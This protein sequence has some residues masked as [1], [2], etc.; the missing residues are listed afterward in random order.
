MKNTL[1]KELFLIL[2]VSCFLFVSSAALVYA[3]CNGNGNGSGCNGSH[4][5][6]G[7]CN[8]TGC[9]GTNEDCENCPYR[10]QNRTRL[11][12]TFVPWQQRT[13]ENCPEACS[14]QGAVVSCTTEDGKIMTITA[15][16][17]GNTI[18]IVVNKTKV[19]TE[20]ELEQE[21]DNVTNSSKFYANKSNGKMS[22]I[23]IM[24]DVASEIALQRLRLKVCNETNNCIIVLKDV[25]T[26][27]ETDNKTLEYEL[28]VQRHVRILGLFQ[29]KAQERAEINAENGKVKIHQPWWMFLATTEN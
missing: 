2:I 15:G 7:N 29:A 23:K 22:E 17:S 14:C 9:N 6:C 25:G 13:E 18:T 12:S 27:N 24:P 16:N 1:N 26:R 3:Q 4:E 5:G 20:L 10:D 8:C 28:Q 19:D 11:N 21:G